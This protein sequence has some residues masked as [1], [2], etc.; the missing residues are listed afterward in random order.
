MTRREGAATL[1]GLAAALSWTAPGWARADERPCGTGALDARNLLLAAHR[2]RESQRYY[3]RLARD[4]IAAV[5]AE[6]RDGAWYATVAN[7][8]AQPGGHD[9]PLVAGAD[10]FAR[11]RDA[12]EAGLRAAPSSPELLALVAYLSVRPGAD[13]P[14]LP[15]DA[16]ARLKDAPARLRGYVCAVAALAARRTDDAVAQLAGIPVSERDRLPDLAELRARAEGQGARQGHRRQRPRGSAGASL[17]LDC[18]P[19]CP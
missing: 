7:V 12:L 10:R 18:D 15:A 8:L 16:C 2:T 13:A 4:S 6:C 9:E 19:F 17:R 5:P 1:M 14:P 11:P 3:L